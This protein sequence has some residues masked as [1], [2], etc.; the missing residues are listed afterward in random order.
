[1]KNES[2]KSVFPFAANDY[3]RALAAKSKAFARQ[4]YPSPEEDEYDDAPLDPFGETGG[5]G[6][7]TGVPGLVQ[8]FPDR[9][10]AM[11]ASSCFMNCR[12]C[13]RRN[14]LGDA[15]TISAPGALAAA[16]EYVQAHPQVRDVLVSGGDPLVLGDDAVM[17]IIDAFAALGQIDVVRLCTRAPCTAPHRIT[18]KL[19][20]SLGASGKVW[21]NTQFNHPDE[22]TPDAVEACRILVESGI[23]VSCQTVMLAGVND[24]TSTMLAL[25]RALQRARVRPYY[26]FQCDPVRGTAHF[27][28]PLE[29]AKR[30]ALECAERIGGLA[31]PRFV[32]DV[33]GATRKIPLELL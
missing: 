23:P 1:M 13:T 20:R 27:R 24:S 5:A 32:A 21:V 26:V 25:F 33:P 9:V 30:I 4:V 19:A 15:A 8:R 14:I 16:L 28:V 31:L 3:S 22:L 18:Q 12:H 11:A 6:A 10:L 17:R 2:Q 29:K 7:C